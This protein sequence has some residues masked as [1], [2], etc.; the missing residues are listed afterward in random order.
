MDIRLKEGRKK[1]FEGKYHDEKL[2][3]LKQQSTLISIF[4]YVEEEKF[5]K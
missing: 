1:K 3:S 4:S 5:L 2:K